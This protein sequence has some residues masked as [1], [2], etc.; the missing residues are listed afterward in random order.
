MGW[1]C[2]LFLH[3]RRTKRTN[4]FKAVDS[5]P[6]FSHNPI[7]YSPWHAS[8]SDAEHGERAGDPR[9]RYPEQL[10]DGWVDY[11]RLDTPQGIYTMMNKL[12]AHQPALLRG[13]PLVAGLAG[14]WS[15]QHVVRRWVVLVGLPRLRCLPTCS[16]TLCALSLGCSSSQRAHLETPCNCGRRRLWG[17]STSCVCCALTQS[18]TASSSPT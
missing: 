13:A 11:L 17:P 16:A 9:P 4:S 15:F 14:R 5:T 12:W 6:P 1:R 18:A 2:V 8:C 3:C 10:A 7:I